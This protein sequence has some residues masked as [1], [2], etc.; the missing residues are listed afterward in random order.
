M[1]NNKSSKR[2]I[3]TALYLAVIIALTIFMN[4]YVTA[5]AEKDNSARMKAL[6]GE[7]SVIITDYTDSAEFAL[8]SYSM[9]KEIRELIADPS[10]PE[11]IAS[12]QKYTDEF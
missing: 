8:S 5:H 12:A 9:A 10:N 3:I 4:I 2:I 6:A 7:R 11:K 1:N